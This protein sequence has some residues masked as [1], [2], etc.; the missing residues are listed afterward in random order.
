M[1]RLILSS[2][3]L[4]A[5]SIGAA[6][7]VSHDI[8]VMGPPIIC[9]PMQIGD[10]KSLPWGEGPFDQGKDYN[11]A[12]VVSDAVNILKADKSLLVHMETLRRATCYV[13]DNRPLATEL[14]ARLTSRA[15]DAEAEAK[16]DSAATAWFDAGFLVACYD[17]IGVDLGYKPGVGDGVQGYAWVKKALSLAGTSPEMD[18]GAALVTH[19]AVT[20]TTEKQYHEHI[21]KAALGAAEGSL[22]EKNVA[23]HLAL[24]GGSLQKARTEAARDRKP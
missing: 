7:A 22:L 11:K 9:H 8:G 23:N 10:A 2:I 19:P 5:L 16:S 12:G 18:Y 21:N 1:R 6:G 17:Q 14:L 13:R 24:W 4:T 15:L 3:A 20:R